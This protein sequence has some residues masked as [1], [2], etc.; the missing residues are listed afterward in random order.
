MNVTHDY[1]ACATFRGGKCTCDEAD[2]LCPQCG[3]EEW[4]YV[5]AER[6]RERD[7]PFNRCYHC[8]H[9]WDPESHA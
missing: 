1:P 7:V 6:G 8:D 4:D 5:A 2:K 9:E 3:S